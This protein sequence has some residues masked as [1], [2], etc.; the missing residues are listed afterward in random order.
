[1]IAYKVLSNNIFDAQLNALPVHL[2]ILVHL[3]LVPLQQFLHVELL[4][5]ERLLYFLH[6]QPFLSILCSHV[7][8]FECL[9]FAYVLHLNQLTRKLVVLLNKLLDLISAVY[10]LLVFFCWSGSKPKS[11]GWSSAYGSIYTASFPEMAK[12]SS[13][14]LAIE[15]L[16]APSDSLL[17]L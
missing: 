3:D 16:F 9:F 7:S 14:F 5:T 6:M 17:S 4:S 11:P 1:V 15:I 10:E 12:L 8:D 2:L 13:D